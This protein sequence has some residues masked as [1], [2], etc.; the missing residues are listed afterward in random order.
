M[1]LIQFPL[2][3]QTYLPCLNLVA[4]LYLSLMIIHLKNYFH[5]QVKNFLSLCSSL[6]PAKYLIILHLAKEFLL[7]LKIVQL[8]KKF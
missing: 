6:H 2:A 5:L 1:H 7:F 4:K 8:L 3:V